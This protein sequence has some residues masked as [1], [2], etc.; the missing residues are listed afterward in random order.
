[1][2]APL[3]AIGIGAGLGL[4]G[5]YVWD[6]VLGDGDYTAREAVVDA[7]GGAIGGSLAKP[8]LKGGGKLAGLTI[9]QKVTHG[10]LN[11]TGREYAEIGAHLMAREV[12]TKPVIKGQVKGA[13]AAHAAG[14]FYDRIRKSSVSSQESYQHGGG[15]GGTA[16][17]IAGT[18]LAGAVLF[19]RPGKS[20]GCPP[21]HYW[22]RKQGRCVPTSTHRRNR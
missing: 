18:L 7:A 21:G 1:M 20:R 11:V 17:K 5:G 4:V 6:R 13:V 9:R 14:Y 19:T 22:S 2:P 15:T 3:V 10:A 8:I 16:E 12:L